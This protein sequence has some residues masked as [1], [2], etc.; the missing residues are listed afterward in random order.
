MPIC[1]KTYKILFKSSFSSTTRVTPPAT[2]T[3]ADGKRFLA[4][5]DKSGAPDHLG[6]PCNRAPRK[7]AYFLPPCDTTC[8][9]YF[10]PWCAQKG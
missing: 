1:L 8:P 3:G 7:V 6:R 5:P 2:G 9:S 10:S 4:A